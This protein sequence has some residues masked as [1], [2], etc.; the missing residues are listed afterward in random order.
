MGFL[1]RLLR[2]SSLKEDE[3]AELPRQTTQNGHQ[4]PSVPGGRGGAT[5]A[6]KR[7]P[8]PSDEEVSDSDDDGSDAGDL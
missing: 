3:A 1:S 5:L 6:G 4:K 2:N 7:P 8:P